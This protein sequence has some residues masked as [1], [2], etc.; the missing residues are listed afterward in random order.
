MRRA[1]W[2]LLVL[3]AAL[4]SGPF[5]LAKIA[6]AELDPLAVVLGRVAVAAAALWAV[7]LMLGI[8]M[9][10]DRRRWRDFALMG[11]LNNV[12]P[13][14]LIFWGQTQIAS[15][16][17]SVLNATTPM[18]TVV[19]AHYLTRDE[20]M[21]ANKIAGM[22]LGIAGVAVLIGPAALGSL[23]ESL[24]GQAAVIG[25]A[26]SYALAGIFGKRFRDLPPLATATGQLTA[27]SLIALPLC[28][29]AGG[30]AL[31][32]MPSAL[33]IAAML[34]LALICTAAAYIVY[35]RLLASAGATNLL[36][37]TILIPVGAI[38]LGVVVLDESFNAR[39]LA[40][41][42]LIGV[43]LLAIDGRLLQGKPV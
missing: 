32:T 10:H 43:A 6:V 18:F 20:R 22:A 26:L 30:L 17:A 19:L 23:G 36:L 34:A 15:G 5:M 41:M 3:L 14:G 4:W 40:G 42:A 38:L 25:A 7:A 8:A 21:S 2:L 16:L 29:L 39:Q 11:L 24:W 28:W 31:H 1:D 33:T 37:V 27:S 9:P 13:F 35:F 12:V